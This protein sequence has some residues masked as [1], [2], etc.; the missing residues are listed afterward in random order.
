[1]PIRSQ[2]QCIR[3]ADEVRVEVKLRSSGE[4]SL[5]NDIFLTEE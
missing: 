1:M 2:S 3:K 5:V 4:K